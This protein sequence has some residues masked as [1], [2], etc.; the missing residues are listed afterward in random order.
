MSGREKDDDE[1]KLVLLAIG[2]SEAAFQELVRRYQ[3]WLRTMLRRLTS[4]AALADDLSQDAFLKAWRRIDTLN[5]HR[6]FR[7]W[8]RRIAV[9]LWIDHCRGQKLQFE[10]YDLEH[11][12]SAPGMGG[13]ETANVRLDLESAL[14]EMRPG[15]RLCVILF[16]AEGMSHS[17]VAAATGLGLGVVKS[18]IARATKR[19]RHTLRSWE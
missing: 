12:A 2:G 9:R 5:D 10:V 18:H 7:A 16:Y 13:V 15:P 4:D 19:L 1:A 14:R 17:E 11:V 8:L 6:L 3:V